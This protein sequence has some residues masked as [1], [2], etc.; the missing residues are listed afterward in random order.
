MRK[1]SQVPDP[2]VRSG[3]RRKHTKIFSVTLELVLEL[4][5]HWKGLL[6]FLQ[7]PDYTG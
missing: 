1:V 4:V 3:V 7:Q 2:I 5:N 6:K